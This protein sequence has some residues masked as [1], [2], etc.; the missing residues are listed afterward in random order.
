[1]HLHPPPKPT[2]PPITP[3]N[4]ASLAALY[5]DENFELQQLLR[6]YLEVL[7]SLGESRK[8]HPHFFN[9]KHE[10]LFCL[11]HLE[12]MKE[13]EA[14]LSSTFHLD[15][16]FFEPR[17]LS[18]LRIRPSLK[19][20]RPEEADFY[21][22]QSKLWNALSEKHKN[23]HRREGVYLHYVLRQL[24]AGMKCGKT[25]SFSLAVISLAR[26]YTSFGKFEKSI[27]LLR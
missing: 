24:K 13:A 11:Y 27:K 2:P 7:N 17:K 12:K 16:S 4:L 5:N 6:E 23:K 10:R 14:L 18:F 1:M 3:F 21:S 15:L 19:I 25:E 8:V 20:L 26:W 9:K 22:L